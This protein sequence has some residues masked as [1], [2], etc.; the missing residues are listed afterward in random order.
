M[1]FPCLWAGEQFALENKKTPYYTP[2]WA[3]VLLLWIELDLEECPILLLFSNW[4]F[5]RFPNELRQTLHRAKNHSNSI[6]DTPLVV[7]KAQWAKHVQKI[8]LIYVCAIKRIYKIHIFQITKFCCQPISNH[9]RTTI[10]KSVAFEL[11]HVFQA[12]F[13][14]A[15]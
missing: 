3:V 1:V 8:F 13:E 9:G 10:P 6:A 14:A 11:C 4:D 15:L 5:F 7:D 12:S 2:L